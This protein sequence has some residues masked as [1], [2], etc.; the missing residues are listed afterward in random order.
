MT[1]DEFVIEFKPQKNIY[2]PY[3]AFDGCLYHPSELAYLAPQMNQHTMWSVCYQDYRRGGKWH[4]KRFLRQG[5][6]SINIEGYLITEVP[7]NM[8]DPF[9]ILISDSIF[10]EDN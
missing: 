5:S 6:T 10:F 7:Y 9:E 3:A 8:N 2:F 4:R 1:F